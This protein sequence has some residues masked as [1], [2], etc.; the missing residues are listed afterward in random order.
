M[1][2][3]KGHKYAKGRPQGAENKEKKELRILITSYLEKNEDKFF[4]ELNKLQSEKYIDRFLQLLEYGLGKLNRVD[5][6]N[7]GERF[8]FNGTN[9]TE[10]IERIIAILDRA[11]ERGNIPKVSSN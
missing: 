5:L 6:T 9:G 7:D 1:P 11:R 2:F 3:E 10:S 8:D 4:K